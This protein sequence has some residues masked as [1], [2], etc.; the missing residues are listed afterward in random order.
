MSTKVAI[1]TGANKGIGLAIVKHLCLQFDGVVYLAARDEERG[2]AAVESLKLV[3]ENVH[4]TQ[5]Y[6]VCIT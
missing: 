3:S 6:F 1:V 5:S 4:T 2:K